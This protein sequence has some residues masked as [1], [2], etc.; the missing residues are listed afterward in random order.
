[1]SRSVH[2]PSPVHSLLF[3]LCL[4]ALPVA[5]GTTSPAAAQE[6]GPERASW[7][8]SEVVARGRERNPDFRVLEA[9]V[10]VAEANAR[11]TLARLLPSASL[12]G[13]WTH[14]DDAVIQGGAV[15]VPADEVGLSGIASLS[16]FSPRAL[17]DHLV[18]RKTAD[19][20]LAEVQWSEEVLTRALVELGIEVALTDALR[21]R[22]AEAAERRDAFLAAAQ[23][24]LDAGQT[25]RAEVQRARLSLLE[26]RASLRTAQA[27][28]LAAAAALAVLLDLPAGAS[29]TVVGPLS[30]PSEASMGADA[31]RR[32]DLLGARLRIEAEELGQSWAW[33]NFLPELTL[34]GSFTQGRESFRNP[35]GF[36]WQ[37]EL[38]ASLVLYDGGARY[39]AI[40]RAEA[41]RALRAA[42][43][44]V[45]E[46]TVSAEVASAKLRVE[47]LVDQVELG[48][49]A[50][51]I[52]TLYRQDVIR[53]RD[54]GLATILDIL[55]A[56]DQLLGAELRFQTAEHSLAR[57]RWRLL[58]AEGGLDAAFDA[59]GRR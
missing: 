38:R 43:A 8:L 37:V 57:A 50:V 7:T 19:A 40:H 33:L 26:A 23:R 27:D 44:D 6:A 24:R 22:A 25:D 48:R 49:E 56:E 31:G 58:L 55:D 20:V 32:G 9:R 17:G 10:A 1:M 41:T 39:G 5:A 53:R 2:R 16:L 15:V 47:A 30:P 59:Q 18:A 36:A 14:N 3:A 12:T 42:E 52:A 54:A 11:I 45:L 21:Q 34:S 28:H 51:Q 35:D 13:T 4:A 46:N 29:I